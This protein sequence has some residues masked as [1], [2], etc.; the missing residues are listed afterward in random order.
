MA[1]QDST[2]PLLLWVLLLAAPLLALGFYLRT[3]DAT[4]ADP[5]PALPTHNS[6]VIIADKPGS[7]PAQIP[8]APVTETQ[9]DEPLVT[10]A[11]PET[12]A[13]ALDPET[14][15]AAVHQ[16][17]NSVYERAT[18]MFEQ[19]Q[20]DVDWAGTYEQSLREMFAQHQG[21]QRVSVN[22][23]SCHSSMCRIEVFTPRDSDADFFTAM[24]YDGLAHFRAGELKAEAVITRRMEQGMTSVY[25]ARSGHTPGFY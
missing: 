15:R 25:V 23:I 21:L 3:G 11:E 2:Q 6:P 7:T 4:V 19:E 8:V 5:L 13:T 16:V 9:A 14:A 17:E 12:T 10:T 24:F 22:S 18:A 20:V 1:R